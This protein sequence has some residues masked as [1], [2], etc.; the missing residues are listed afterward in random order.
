MASRTAATR[1]ELLRTRRQLV[2]VEQGIALTRRKRE[3][4]VAELFRAAAP[5]MARRERLARDAD[6]ASDAVRQALADRGLHTLDAIARPLR[7]PT[8]MLT[9]TWLW[10]MPYTDLHAV[11]APDGSLVA[12]DRAPAMAGPAVDLAARRYAAFAAQLVETAPLEQ[13]LRRLADAV[14]ET[15]RRLRALEQRLAPS[16]T[17][18]TRRIRAA[19]DEREREEHVRLR[20]VRDTLQRRR[21]A[22]H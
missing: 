14:A 5:A 20:H 18:Q 13:R 11:E 2:R 4:L 1:A 8:V 3:A 22:E 15:N 9:P 16:L 17:A 19:L 21:Q 6:A 10:G 7:T 12:R